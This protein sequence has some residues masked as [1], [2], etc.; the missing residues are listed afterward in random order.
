M[1]TWTGGLEKDRGYLIGVLYGDGFVQHSKEIPVAFGMTVKEKVFA[2]IFEICCN[3]CLGIETKRHEYT[4]GGY[5]GLK[6]MQFCLH[7]SVVLSR[8]IKEKYGPTDTFNWYIHEEDFQNKE[9]L[10]G[11]LSGLFDSDGWTS[12]LRLGI[13][14]A[15]QEGGE[16][17]KRGLQIL[18]MN[19]NSHDKTEY[20]GTVMYYVCLAGKEDLQKF[21]DTVG[22]RIPRKVY[23]LDRVLEGFKNFDDLVESLAKYPENWPFKNVSVETTKKILESRKRGVERKAI[24]AELGLSIHSI[25]YV[26]TVFREWG[27]LE[28]FDFLD[29]V[30]KEK[31]EKSLKEHPR[32]LGFVVGV[33]KRKWSPINKPKEIF[34][35]TRLPGLV[36]KFSGCFRSCFSTDPA[37]WPN[38]KDPRDLNVSVSDKGL[39]SALEA[40]L[41]PFG[42]ERWNVNPDWNNALGKDFVAGL[43]DGML[44]IAKGSKD[45][46]DISSTNREAVTN[47]F[48]MCSCE[49]RPCKLYCNSDR[50]TVR[51]LK[52]RS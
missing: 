23:L 25:D 51:V 27:V 2:D 8:D 7:H 47:I 44:S 1:F 5:G 17:V 28:K 6:Q 32:E 31:L 26:L 3:K 50:A 42:E 29:S 37:A 10:G 15:S 11:I 38:K 41:G 12:N 49:G 33:L 43:I 45:S 39:V 30:G 35:R 14:T 52:T 34:F 48:S 9:F 4:I 20:N 13:A 21:K 24:A 18:G 22:F 40:R 46:Y 16:S 36:S 19:P